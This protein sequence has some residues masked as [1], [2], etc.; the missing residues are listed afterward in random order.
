M[1]KGNRQRAAG[2]RK[3]TRVL[4]FLL[5]AMIWAMYSSAGA[6]QPQKIARVGFFAPG[7]RVL[8]RGPLAVEFI[9]LKSDVIVGARTLRPDAFN[10]LWSHKHK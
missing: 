9:Q 8:G 5:G 7:F 3:K 4:R 6:Q 10:C 1:R 2:N